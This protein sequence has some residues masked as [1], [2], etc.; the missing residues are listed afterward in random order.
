[1]HIIRPLRWLPLGVYTMWSPSPPLRLRRKLPRAR[2][3]NS[4]SLLLDPSG[5]SLGKEGE[6]DVNSVNYA[7]RRKH[8][9]TSARESAGSM[10]TGR[11]VDTSI[12]KGTASVADVEGL[13][14]GIP[15]AEATWL[16]PSPPA[17]VRDALL[18]CR[19]TTTMSALLT[20]L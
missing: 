6:Y 11:R 3:G 19:T 20:I 1:M 10:S 12:N 7:R 15:L 9:P 8:C 16:W 13:N 17:F 4:E 18:I 14:A 2:Q 5:I